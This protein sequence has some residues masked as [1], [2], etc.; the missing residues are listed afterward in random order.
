MDLSALYSV[1]AAPSGAH[2]VSDH[3]QVALLVVRHDHPNQS[4]VECIPLGACVSLE[5]AL[6]SAYTAG[7]LPAQQ[8]P[9]SVAPASPAALT[10]SEPEPATKREPCPNGC[11]TQLIPGKPGRHLQTGP[12]RPAGAAEDACRPN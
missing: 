6:R 8:P 12:K 3:G 7:A 5:E 4:T 2:F 10:T 1:F 9:I 11:G